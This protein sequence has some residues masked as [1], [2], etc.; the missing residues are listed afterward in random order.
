MLK[1][2]NISKS[3]SNKIVLKNVNMD[4]LDNG[5]YIIRG[6]SGI[7]K[8]TLL[9][10]ILGLE[11]PEEGQI[12]YN[13]RIINSLNSKKRKQFRLDKIGSI[14]QEHNL[15]EHFTVEENL[16]IIKTDIDGEIDPI[17]KSLD[18]Y[19]HKNKL[20]NELSGGERQR[21]AIARSIYKNS[22]IIIADEPTS[23]LDLET[24]KGVLDI[25]K[26]LSKNRLVIV[27]SHENIDFS[28]YADCIYQ[29]ESNSVINCTKINENL[30]KAVVFN[31]R[32][33]KK[34]NIIYASKLML[35]AITYNKLKFIASFLLLSLLLL[36]ITSITTL[37]FS[38][39]SKMY[40]NYI[41]NS[42]TNYELVDQNG[43]ELNYTEY[44]ELKNNFSD[45]DY[46]LN[47]I[48][49]INSTVTVYKLFIGDDL[50][51][52]EILIS[53][54]LANQMV[55]TQYQDATSEDELYGLNVSILD[56]VFNIKGLDSNQTLGSYESYI[57]ISDD[58]FKEMINNIE[59]YLSA[60]IDDSL[61]TNYYVD[62]ISNLSGDEIVLPTIANSTYS[63]GDRVKI[64]VIVNEE[65]YEYWFTVTGFS[66]SNAQRFYISNFKLNEIK[67][68]LLSGGVIKNGINLDDFNELENHKIFVSSTYINN[69]FEFTHIFNNYLYY[70]LAAYLLLIIL[71]YNIFKIVFEHDIKSNYSDYMVLH[72][73]GDN[74]TSKH[75]MLLYG[76]LN[77]TIA[78]IITSVIFYAFQSR[79]NYIVGELIFPNIS[80]KFISYN[81]VII[82]ILTLLLYLQIYI[83][84]YK[85]G[86]IKMDQ[87]R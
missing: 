65:T 60:S 40:F 87:S 24:A 81:F 1:I 52:N 68:Q 55:I 10:L 62:F 46:Y 26:Q 79:M 33:Y 21:V 70:I 29:I 13:D 84:E 77:N 72:L 44:S 59:L 19:V 64:S 27:V 23:N 34:H 80:Y 5:F 18:I 38:D 58:I 78:F 54:F 30:P 86:K 17:L 66:D 85:I 56:D 69:Y 22:E 49:P 73:L 48:E 25:L 74:K 76:S 75:R 7:G 32:G 82:F 41:Q 51:N 20:V 14:F 45:I 71:Y 11:T 28:E 37:V 43:N 35:N 36:L 50:Q 8:T 4:F 57:V 39:Y 63:I 47:V 15:I 61:Y 9:N 6:K 31:N 16:S 42:L 2:K 3:F 83:Q 12:I 53:E 67:Y